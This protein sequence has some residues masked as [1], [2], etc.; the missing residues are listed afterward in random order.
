MQPTGA[1]DHLAAVQR[2]YDARVDEWRV[3]YD[4][5][6]FH[7]HTIRERLERTCALAGAGAGRSALDV[8][9]GAGQ[10]LERL[11]AAG[12]DVQGT[13]LSSGMVAE[14]GA[15]LGDPA[16]VQQA[17]AT[18]LPHADGSLDLVTALGL[19]EYLPEPSAGLRD[20]KRVLRPGGRLIVTV[21]N[22]VRL[23]YLLDPIGA[24]RRRLAP[25]AG[26]YPR[27][28]W[29]PWAFR[30]DLKA[31]GLQIEHVEGHGLGP[32]TFLGKPLLSEER[33]I[34]LGQRLQRVLPRALRDLLGANLIAVARA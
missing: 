12:W 28:Y 9:C 19:I 27:A 29:T 34:A 1:D 18:K 2:D 10:L 22:K 20:M 14:A 24:I 32:I 11:A 6:T 25:P 16:K 26:G 13:D 15:R 23:A 7:D 30:R 21:P 5:Q 3:I 4:G 17:D 33:A 8:G 31:A